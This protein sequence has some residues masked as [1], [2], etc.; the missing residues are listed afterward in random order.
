MNVSN[1]FFWKNFILNL[2]SYLPFF[3][4]IDAYNI[5][6]SHRDSDSSV[7]IELIYVEKPSKTTIKIDGKVYEG[8]VGRN[9]VKVGKFKNQIIKIAKSLQWLL[10]PTFSFFYSMFK[11][12]LLFS[13]SLF[14]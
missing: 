7:E 11:F 9:E 6:A 1:F 8:D 2:C 4:K 10:V 5:Q 3:K 14:C 13:T 12:L